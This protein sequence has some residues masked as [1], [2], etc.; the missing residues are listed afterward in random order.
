MKKIR[1]TGNY[2]NSHEDLIKYYFYWYPDDNFEVYIKGRKHNL[3][4]ERDYCKENNRPDSEND[5][6]VFQQEIEELL[7]RRDPL[8]MVNKWNKYNDNKTY[9][10]RKELDKDR[11]LLSKENHRYSIQKIERIYWEFY[12][13]DENFRDDLI[14]TDINELIKMKF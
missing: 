10:N 9:K 6:I 1:Y 3:H 4:F 12:H 13:E 5:Y 14:K 11:P 8:E 2:H 7:E